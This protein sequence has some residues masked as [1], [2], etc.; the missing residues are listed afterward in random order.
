[1]AC[2]RFRVRVPVVPLFIFLIRHSYTVVEHYA[3][4]DPRNG[5]YCRKGGRKTR[6]KDEDPHDLFARKSSI[7]SSISQKKTYGRQ[8]EDV[9]YEIVPVVV[10]VDEE[11]EIETYG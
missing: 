4:R 1:M 7:K 6:G 9:E 11:G 8:N 2:K 5:K 10:S 3:I